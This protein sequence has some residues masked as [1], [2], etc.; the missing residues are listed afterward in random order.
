M[1]YLDTL[2]PVTPCGA[3]PSTPSSPSQQQLRVSSSTP[4]AQAAALSSFTYVLSVITVVDEEKK[5]SAD[6]LRYP[7]ASGLGLRYRTAGYHY[8]GAGGRGA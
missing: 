1:A 5:A 8:S 2:D 7:K 3:A 6:C 4:S